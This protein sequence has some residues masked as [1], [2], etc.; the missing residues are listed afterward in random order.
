MGKVV[1]PMTDAVYGHGSQNLVVVKQAMGSEHG[2]IARRVG[3]LVDTIDLCG[4]T[5]TRKLDGR[6]ILPGFGFTPDPFLDPGDR[7]GNRFAFI[8]DRMVAVVGRHQRGER[9]CRGG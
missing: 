9:G 2:E 7:L 8:R 6:A 1:R 5:R 4:I 3:G